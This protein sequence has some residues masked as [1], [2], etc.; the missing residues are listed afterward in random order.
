[1]KRGGVREDGPL[2]KWLRTRFGQRPLRGIARELAADLLRESRQHGAPIDPFRVFPERGILRYERKAMSSHGRLR[3]TDGGFVIETPGGHPSRVRFTVAHEVGHTLFF[4]LTQS[5]PRRTLHS[6]TP[7]EEEFFCDVFASELLMPVEAMRN[8]V[9]RRRDNEAESPAA[10]IRHLAE[11]FRV[12]AETAARR[13]IEDLEILNGIALGARWLPGGG[14]G[15]SRRRTPPDWRLAWWAASSELAK[16]TYLP[17]ASSRPK[18]RLKSVDG[19]YRQGRGI[20]RPTDVTEAG[21]GNLRAVIRKKGHDEV[22]YS[23]EPVIPKGIQIRSGVEDRHVEDPNDSL[24]SRSEI[25]A[26]F[27]LPRG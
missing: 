4:D 13:L 5:P 12:S 10:S 18:V 27:D 2:A 15:G 3:V 17:A 21:L 25:I 1:M 20:W 16:D 7:E 8:H 24:K 6:Q 11:A 9:E 19:V 23:V 26:F 14:V 22:D